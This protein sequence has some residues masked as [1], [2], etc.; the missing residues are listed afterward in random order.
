MQNI[1]ER[2][3]EVTESKGVSG[4]ELGKLLGLKKSPL[5]D[6]K[7][8][9][10]RP[11]LIHLIIICENFG[12]SADYILFGREYSRDFTDWEV[13]LISSYR[14]LSDVEK[15]ILLGRLETLL[16]DSKKKPETIV[17][18]EIQNYNITTLYK[19]EL[20]GDISAGG[21]IDAIANRE[22]I[23]A[24]IKCDFALRI[25][26]DSMEPTFKNH[27]IIFLNQDCELKYN[28]EI[29]AVQVDD[30]TSIAFLK[31]VYR[32]EETIRLVS[33]NPTYDDIVLPAEKVTILGKV[34]YPLV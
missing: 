4:V 32:K 6:W 29:A 21:G 3:I 24:P 10:S 28:G 8:G 31:K 13:Y 23:E 14:R 7:N 34:V 22:V 16:E 9:Q 18:E 2:I 33:I 25:K 5:T 12:I 27:S 19:V 26:G 11:T 20:W 30:F 17:D 1:I 15:G